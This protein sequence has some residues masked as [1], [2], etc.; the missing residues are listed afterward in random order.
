M[1]MPMLEIFG[2]AFALLLVLFVI[3]NMLNSSFSTPRDEETIDEGEYKISWGDD[4]SGYVVIAYPSRLW[5]IEEQVSVPRDQICAAD[6]AF[7]KYAF[8]KYSSKDKQIIFTILD[9][10]VK[11]TSIAR[12]CIREIFP[13]IPVSIGWI[14][15]NSE[16]LKAINLKEI[17]PYVGDF[18]NE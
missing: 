4:G 5:I 17:P 8:S 2:G 9:D 1:D 3:I 7:V 14:V 6:S 12:N 10:A 13:T 18:I 16:F 11:T 15:A